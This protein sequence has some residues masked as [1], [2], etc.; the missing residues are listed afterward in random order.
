MQT[1]LYA[2]LLVLVPPIGIVPIVPA[3][4]MMELIDSF[5]T[6]VLWDI[7]SNWY[8]PSHC[9]A[10]GFRHGGTFLFAHCCHPLGRDAAPLKPGRYSVFSSLYVR[11]WI[12]TLATEVMLDT[13]SSIFATIYMRTWYRLMGAK[14]GKGSEISTNLAGRYD[15]IDIGPGNFIADDVQLG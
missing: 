3:F 8:Y 14:I 13:L 15:L 1:A 4:R 6:P 5:L 12:V 2:I 10:G 9:P 11:K 7:N